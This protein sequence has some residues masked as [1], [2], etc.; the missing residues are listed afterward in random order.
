MLYAEFIEKWFG[1]DELERLIAD[2]AELIR[3]YV[4]KD[5]T[6]FCTAEE[7]DTG[8]QTM[9]QFVTLRAEA[10]S[11]QLEGD[12]AAVETGDLNL[13]D[14]GRMGGG[15]G[16]GTDR[17][18]DFSAMGGEQ[19]GDKS[20]RTDS[21]VSDNNTADASAD[22]PTQEENAEERPAGGFDPSR[23]GQND[24]SRRWALIRVT[25]RLPLLRPDRR[26]RQNGFWSAYRLL[27]WL[28]GCGSL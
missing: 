9:Q 6:K 27:Y 13:S 1:N 18:F 26:I 3:P 11:R 20:N 17:G 23:F 5:P 12:G 16:G 8:I 28:R 10:V 7:F 24:Q 15:L 22:L 14:M 4:E 19:R 25:A 21:E 2:T